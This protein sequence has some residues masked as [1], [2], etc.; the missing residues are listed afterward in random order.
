MRLM[1]CKKRSTALIE[2][3]PWIG[4][5]LLV[6]GGLFSLVSGLGVIRFPTFFTRLHAAGILDTAGA[7]LILVG[8]MFQADDVLI[9]L[10]CLLILGF[11]VF[12]SPTACHALAR[13]AL[14]DGLLPIAVR[15]R[16]QSKR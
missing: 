10:K 15:R 9:A 14:H 11:L 5:P 1:F 2:W 4:A 12:T 8:L 16:N 6:A 13:A 7:G 3:L